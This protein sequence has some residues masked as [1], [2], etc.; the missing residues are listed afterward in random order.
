MPSAPSGSRDRSRLRRMLA[1]EWLLTL[2]GAVLALA[3]L[4]A[5]VVVP[6]LD[7]SRRIVVEAPQPSPLQSVSLVEINPGQRACEDEIGL[8]PGRQVAEMRVGTYGKPVAPLLVELVA[9]G[10]R[11]R[12]L[13]PPSY[14]DNG[15][16]EV[17]VGGS[18]KPV[19]GRVCVTNR[20]RSM[21]ALYASA[22]RTK[23]RSS[24]TVG[25]RL[26]PA[27][28]DLTFYAAAKHSLLERAGPT[29]KRLRLFHAHVGIGLLWLLALLFVIGVPLATLTS[30]GVA[31]HDSARR[32][33]PVSGRNGRAARRTAR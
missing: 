18:Q 20:G 22:D 29:V 23:S 8:L 14:V 13:V 1:D 24:T 2:A 17:P 31:D 6:Y 27:N 12:I 28:F 4:V 26:W 16:I 25:G 10:Y 15:P 30:I 21:V 7:Q 33:R 32:A 11:E 19:Q 9:P 3:V 5:V